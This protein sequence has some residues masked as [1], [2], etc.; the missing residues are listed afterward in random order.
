MLL[1]MRAVDVISTGLIPTNSSADYSAIPI[2]DL[3]FSG[4]WVSTWKP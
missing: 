3:D 4:I 2:F 1:K